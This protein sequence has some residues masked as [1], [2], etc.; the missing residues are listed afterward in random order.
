MNI[1]TLNN[2]LTNDKY[3]FIGNIN[4]ETQKLIDKVTNASI[5]KDEFKILEKYYIN[6]PKI[7]KTDKVHIFNY[8]IEDYTIKQLKLLL[9]SILNIPIEKIHVY[10][11]NYNNND[12][13]KNSINLRLQYDNSKIK[14]NENKLNHTLGYVFNGLNGIK[15]YD[16]NIIS[17]ID[18]ISRLYFDYEDT[19][20]NNHHNII[21]NYSNKSNIID[22]IDYDN[23]LIKYN[24]LETK[25]ITKIEE[26]YFPNIKSI[27]KEELTENNKEYDT[28]FNEV[29]N[30]NNS[31]N[32]LNFD[33]NINVDSH[34]LSN[35]V[36]YSNINKKLNLSLE[37]VYNLFKL[38]SSIPFIK[39]RN[40]IRHD[41]YKIYE[42]AIFNYSVKEN[43]TNEFNNYL[44][45][46]IPYKPELSNPIIT[47]KMLEHWKGN[48]YNYREA[49]YTETLIKN[50]E[51]NSEEIA[52]KIHCPDIHINCFCT[53]VIYNTGLIIIKIIDE[54]KNYFYFNN[55][56]LDN[57]YKKIDNILADLHKYMSIHKYSL[58]INYKKIISVNS[59]STIKLDSKKIVTFKSIKDSINKYYTKGYL[60]EN[61][62]YNITIKY[63]A[64]N[65]YMIDEHLSIYF[66]LLREIYKSKN[67]DDFKQIWINE[68]KLKFNMSAIDALKQLEL[69]SQLYLD[70]PNI[71]I[72]NDH[73]N[74]IISKT[75]S[76][77][78]FSITII[79]SHIS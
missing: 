33:K 43:I 36:I 78:E 79:N 18:D 30:C 41:F 19:L 75:D 69:L 17:I 32:N 59:Q 47:K 12:D 26:I 49:K 15:Y 55:D 27:I 9:F 38:N 28:L 4:D 8:S 10:I 35:I 54:D 57:L 3:I 14:I 58:N 56:N 25:D 73:V 1:F 23:L 64:H 52:L 44:N 6:F 42:P 53:L 5:S 76:N 22:F 68:S 72:N 7:K 11:K 31:Y 65:N 62:E 61:D 34:T 48:V 20:I 74:I 40:F 16:G 39:Y 70:E 66:R 37:T 2:T 51:L 21:K 67:I 60:I 50:D 24:T 13:I 77:N 46:L 45:Y 71:K 63:K 29:N